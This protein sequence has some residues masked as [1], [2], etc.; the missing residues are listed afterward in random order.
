[1]YMFP[2]IHLRINQSLKEMKQGKKLSYLHMLASSPN[3]KYGCIS[4]ISAIKRDI[5]PIKSS[6]IPFSTKAVHEIPGPACNPTCT[7][8]PVVVIVNVADI[9]VYED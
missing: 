3:F 7:G 6:L 2:E 8:L 9:R 4:T 5:F 1:M